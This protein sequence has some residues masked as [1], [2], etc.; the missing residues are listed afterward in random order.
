[1]ALLK[2]AVLCF[3]MA[4]WAL[5]LRRRWALHPA[6]LPAVLC[7]GVISALFFAGV[8]HLFTPM[9]W[10]LTL[11]GAGLFAYQLVDMLKKNTLLADLRSLLSPGLIFFF[12]MIAFCALR[13]RGTALS[14]IDEYKHWG[15]ILKNMN[16]E[17]QLPSWQSHY[18]IFQN[19]PPGSALFI[20]YITRFIGFSESRAL[21][22]QA[23]LSTACVITP[24][25]FC[26]RSNKISSWIGYALCTGFAI[27]MMTIVLGIGSLLVD[28]L[29]PAVGFAA[30]A[31]LWHGRQNLRR[32][33]WLACPLAI[34][35]ML[36]KNSGIFFVLIHTGV[37]L[38]LALRA[39]PAKAVPGRRRWLAGMGIALALPFFALLLWNGYV[40]FAYENAALS[41]HA[42]RADFFLETIKNRPAQEYGAIFSLFMAT[43]F[44]FSNPV[45]TTTL[46]WCGTLCAL[47]VLLYRSQKPLAR[48][49][50]KLV[51]AVGGVFL[52]YQL[53]LLLMYFFSM[54]M[55]ED[56]QLQEY[57][58]Y[59]RTILPYLAGLVCAGLVQVLQKIELSPG[60][61]AGA[62]YGAAALA[63]AAA[64]LWPV[65]L[66][67][68]RFHPLLYEGSL[69]QEAD[70]MAAVVRLSGYEP[71]GHAYS[72]LIFTGQP[73]GFS[74][75]HPYEL[76][77]RYTLLSPNVTVV[78]EDM[79]LEDDVFADIGQYSFILY[80]EESPLY[81]QFMAQY[82]VE[83][84]YRELYIPAEL[85]AGSAAA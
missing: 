74:E 69:N 67:T 52:A 45:L 3:S 37:L 41:P 63:L 75:M 46:L 57:G 34:S 12:V 13:T 7:G 38:V 47:A 50:F 14:S 51:L 26:G 4:G 61:F 64:L 15:L 36:I 32:A 58:R 65:P 35:T 59:A 68:G 40:D 85:L 17:N 28:G 44:S 2:M 79:T 10:A 11:G 60:V 42:M 82:G 20:Y 54:W 29:L 1:M 31:V 43:T 66:Q 24:F 80:M 23:I 76:I 5:F 19:Y 25:A 72:Y 48:G 78:S 27:Y 33:A 39:R 8:W 9:V 81:R 83:G 77:L 49:L 6:F 30:L 70:R 21:L 16:L 53:G 62:A 55:N 71:T 18:M 84:A 22:A 56:G 73:G